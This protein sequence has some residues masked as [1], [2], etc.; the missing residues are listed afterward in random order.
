MQPDTDLGFYILIVFRTIFLCRLFH[1]YAIIVHNYQIL[2]T[3]NSLKLFGFFVLR[4]KAKLNC[5]LGGEKL[6]IIVVGR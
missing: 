2:K 3:T 6:F 4:G 5:P 1:N